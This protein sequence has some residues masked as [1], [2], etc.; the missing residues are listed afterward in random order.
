MEMDNYFS[1]CTEISDRSVEIARNGDCMDI[2]AQ[3]GIRREWAEVLEVLMTQPITKISALQ[4]A[5]GFSVT[6]ST[7]KQRTV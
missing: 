7:G 4:S 2:E 3:E 5:H 6:P 1:L